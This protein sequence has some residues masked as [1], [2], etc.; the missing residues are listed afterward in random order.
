MRLLQFVSND[1]L[2][3]AED[4]ADDEL[5]SHSYAILSHT[6][7]KDGEEVSFADLKFGSGH[8]KVGYK[9]RRFCGEQAANDG[10]QY[11]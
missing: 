10:L 8:T 1:D 4:L 2:C 7:G 5:S 11:V 3:L 6:W 9:K